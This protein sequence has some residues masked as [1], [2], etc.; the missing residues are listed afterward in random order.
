MNIMELVRNDI[1]PDYTMITSKRP[2]KNPN[3][4]WK[5]GSGFDVFYN[6][7]AFPLI[8]VFH[9]NSIV[10]RVTVKDIDTDILPNAS[11]VHIVG[12]AQI[13]SAYQGQ[14]LGLELYRNLITKQNWALGGYDHSAGARKLWARLSMEPE[15]VVYVY[16]A[17][18][19]LTWDIPKI[20]GSELNLSKRDIY[21]GTYDYL[22]A[23]H[24][25]GAAD[26]YIKNRLSISLKTLKK[27]SQNL[28][29][30]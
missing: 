27:K 25:N 21:N 17:H 26:R 6:P 15:I 14:N 1:A 10:A 16:N 4:D 11:P 23:V 8:R 19:E 22:V 13:K 20:K 29:N 30:A 12:V 28:P 18:T 2:R 5:I 9:D 24:K 7:G 3:I